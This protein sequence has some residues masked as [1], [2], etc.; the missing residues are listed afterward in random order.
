MNRAFWKQA[1]GAKV[2]ADSLIDMHPLRRLERPPPPPE[3]VEEAAAMDWDS[4]ERAL[5]GIKPRGE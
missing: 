5:A 3:E 2:T 1:F 4:F